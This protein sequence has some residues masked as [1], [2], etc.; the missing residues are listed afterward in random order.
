LEFIGSVEFSVL[1]PSFVWAAPRAEVSLSL[2]TALVKMPLWSTPLVS[3]P[4]SPSEAPLEEVLGPP[5]KG[6]TAA[7]LKRSV[8]RSFFDFIFCCQTF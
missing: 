7:M 1:F 2:L 4:I 8:R 5:S 6:A 3:V